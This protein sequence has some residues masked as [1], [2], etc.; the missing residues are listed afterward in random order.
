MGTSNLKKAPE[1]TPNRH[2]F[3]HDPAPSLA[4]EAR[5]EAP[6]RPGLAMVGLRL[7]LAFVFLWAFLDKLLGLGFATAPGAAWVN[8][9]SPTSGFLRFAAEGPLAE[10]YHGLAGLALVDWLFML[11]L[12]G[13]GLALLLGIGMRIAAWSGVTLML[14]MYAA[15][16]PP[17]NNPIVDDHVV[18]AFALLVLARSRAGARWGLG[19]P[20]SRL[21]LVRKHR[22]LE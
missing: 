14:L 2:R 19:R 3:I 17:E 9:G 6:D 4:E 10:A 8:G 13:I 5:H 11:G 18:Y 1:V 20:W 15:L 16:L 21:P 22:V 7:S 12:L